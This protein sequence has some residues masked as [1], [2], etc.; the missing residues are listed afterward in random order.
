MWTDKR[1]NENDTMY[2]IWK[3][4][5]WNLE[6]A[7]RGVHPNTQHIGQKWLANSF[8]MDK[9]WVFGINPDLEYL[10]NQFGLKCQWMLLDVPCQ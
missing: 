5:V 9:L 3:V 8:F 6:A 10:Q 2:A 7:F 1:N 4:L